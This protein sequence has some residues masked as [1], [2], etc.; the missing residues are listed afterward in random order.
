MESASS[1]VP[2]WVGGDLMWKKRADRWSGTKWRPLEAWNASRGSKKPVIPLEAEEQVALVNCSN[3]R[4]WGTYFFHVPNERVNK[5]EAIRGK[6]QGV[7][8]GVPD[9][10]LILRRAYGGV[11][12]SGLVIELKRRDATKSALKLEQQDW[13]SKTGGQGFLACVCCGAAEAI[14]VL[15][16]YWMH[17][18]ETVLGVTHIMDQ[19]W[20][21]T[22]VPKRWQE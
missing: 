18:L 2:S 12:Y 3:M 8:A 19:A 21:H 4:Q 14:K 13:L 17:R 11:D 20:P 16:A 15:D 7:R 6:Q 10:W 1:I 5:L 22:W 9:N